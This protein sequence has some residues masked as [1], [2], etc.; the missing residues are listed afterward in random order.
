MFL[1]EMMVTV[2]RQAEHSRTVFNRAW[3]GPPVCCPM[4]S[5]GLHQVKNHLAVRTGMLLFTCWRTMN[6]QVLD[7]GL[8]GMVPF[9]TFL[10]IVQEVLTATGDL[11]YIHHATTCQMF[12]TFLTYVVG[13]TSVHLEMLSQCFGC[14]KVLFTKVA[15]DGMLWWL[16]D[17]KGQIPSCSSGA[18]Q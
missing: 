11:V 7:Q 12:P 8:F 3:E 18:S 5:H 4:I 14:R 9:T 13:L 2:L 16:G 15:V 10:A 1:P 17:I 6:L